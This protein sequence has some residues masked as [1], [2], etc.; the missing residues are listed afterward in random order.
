MDRDPE[1]TADMA[2]ETALNA[3]DELMTLAA[4]DDTA[5]LVIANRIFV[6]QIKSRVDLILSFLI[7]KETPAFKVISNARR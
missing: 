4:K 3:L 6:G 2:C 7:A 1:I 5:H